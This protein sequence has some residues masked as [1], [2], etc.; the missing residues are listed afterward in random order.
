MA[1][2]QDAHTTTG[3]LDSI[4]Q[5]LRHRKLSLS[6]LLQLGLFYGIGIGVGVA[7]FVLFFL[8]HGLSFIHIFFYRGLAIIATACLLHAVMMTFALRWFSARRISPANVV[9]VVAMAAMLNLTFFTL[10]PVNL[11]RSISVFLLA[12]MDKNDDRPMSRADLRDVF[13]TVY[14][15]RYAAIER[16]INEQVASGN[17]E[18]LPRGYALTGRGRL[19]NR[20]ARAVGIVFSVDPR[21]LDPRCAAGERVAGLAGCETPGIMARNM[22]DVAPAPG[23]R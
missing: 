10:V 19:F 7:L 3:L 23:L 14:V 9:S 15:T 22:K 16:R 11:D 13:Q 2:H 17:I 20:F 5:H 12:W 8:A 21:F 1:Y 18:L 4:S 6:P